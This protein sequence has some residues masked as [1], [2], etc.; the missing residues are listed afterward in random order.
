MDKLRIRIMHD[1][2]YSIHANNP[3]ELTKLL[4]KAKTSG[5]QINMNQLI[6]T[7]KGGCHSIFNLSVGIGYLQIVEILIKY[8]ADINLIHDPNPSPLNIAISGNKTNIALLLIDSG[9]N[10]HHHH[11]SGISPLM[12]AIQKNCTDIA[13]K[14]IDC[15]A[16]INENISITNKNN[17]TIETNA[18]AFCILFENIDVFDKLLECNVETNAISTINK[19]IYPF[20]LDLAINKKNKHMINALLQNKNSSKSFPKSINCIICHNKTPE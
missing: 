8:G 6:D 9:A 10:I 15:G 14:L 18:L 16:N 2:V 3:A 19:R 12:H 20:A 5:I 1:I 13:I 4:E 7:E 17:N 11:I